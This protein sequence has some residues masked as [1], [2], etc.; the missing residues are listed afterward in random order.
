MLGRIIKSVSLV[1]VLM[2]AGS[3]LAANPVTTGP[4]GGAF[5][6]PVV[7][8]VLL[9]QTGLT[10]GTGP[11]CQDFE[12]AYDAY[13]NWVADDFTVPAPDVAWDVNF[14]FI[15]GTNTA[16][17]DPPTGT[18]EFYT[19]VGG[20]PG[21][22]VCASATTNT[23]DTSGPITMNLDTP[24]NLPAGDYWMAVQASLDFGTS[25][26]FFCG[27][28]DD[29]VGPAVLWQNPLDGFA[30]GCTTWGTLATC[31]SNTTASLM[32]LLD[33]VVVPVELQSYSVE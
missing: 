7:R 33:G 17:I 18:V 3:V 15:P 14:V 8:A 2:V 24:C 23:G 10:V 21:V 19:N 1:G 9:D 32:F 27:G 31:L 13:D 4:V 16:A 28:A 22:L 30:S 11:T 6:P 25:G 29:P 20:L 5:E 12:T 26:Q